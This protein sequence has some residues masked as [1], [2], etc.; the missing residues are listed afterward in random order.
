M[1]LKVKG[2]FLSSFKNKIFL[3]VLLEVTEKTEGG[4]AGKEEGQETFGTGK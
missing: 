3:L 2:M 4:E 1:V